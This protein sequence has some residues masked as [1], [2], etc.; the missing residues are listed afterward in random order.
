MAGN[1]VN[2]SGGG[3][4]AP[5]TWWGLGAIA[6]V[7][8][9]CGPFGLEAT[10]FYGGATWTL[11]AV[12]AVPLLYV[13]PQVLMVSEL[14][15]MMPSNHGYILWV[16]RG[17]GP[18]AG[19]FNG[20]NAVIVNTVDLALYP[21]LASD[22]V[23]RLF[24]RIGWVAEGETVG[25][26]DFSSRTYLVAIATRLTLIAV[27][28]FVGCLSTANVSS[29]SVIVCVFVT[30]V[31]VGLFCATLPEM[32]PKSQITHDAGM[33]P[34]FDGA[35]QWGPFTAAALWL[36]TGWN[37][38][39]SLAGDVD[40][41]DDDAEDGA[42]NTST[43]DKNN[44]GAMAHADGAGE[45]V[46]LVDQQPLAPMTALSEAQQRQMEATEAHHAARGLDDFYSA[47]NVRLERVPPPEILTEGD[48]TLDRSPR[49]SPR[50][51]GLAESPPQLVMPRVVIASS[52][53]PSVPFSSSSNDPL[54]ARMRGSE[55][56]TPSDPPT[57]PTSAGPISGS[58][59]SA[60]KGLNNVFVRGL[61][62]ALILGVILYLLPLLTAL[63]S[64]EAR[65][66][67]WGDGFLVAAMDMAVPG[68][69][70]MLIFIGIV[71]QFGL[72]YSSL[73]C[74]SRIVWG[75][76]ELGWLPAFFAKLG[77]RNGTP[78]NATLAQS[79]ALVPLMFF[80]F[81]YLQRLEFT[82][83]C[84]AYCLTFTAFL[85]LRYN[86]PN[87][88]RPYTVPGGL[89]IAWLITATK[90]VV[91]VTVA[92][93]NAA[94]PILLGVAVGI[95][96]LIGVAYYFSDGRKRAAELEAKEAEAEGSQSNGSA[97]AA[98]GEQV[99]TY[100]PVEMLTTTDTTVAVNSVARPF[101]G[102]YAAE[103]PRT[104]AATD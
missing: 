90:V 56:T 52:S 22:Y 15:L 78:I 9:S 76:A 43:A 92:A 60:N 14:A 40:N 34:S 50:G 80:D 65:D 88:R 25:N 53:S 7:M 74:Y 48:L 59:S 31:F 51:R 27:G 55:Q 20:Y 28:T 86:E 57:S 67:A 70:W 23:L 103:S 97:A 24:G 35:V 68:A 91:M 39:G 75:L 17:W 30:A 81:S 41:G 11:I 82:L 10:M 89:P 32:D 104:C 102:G 29:I 1:K 37:S 19:F 72:Y 12:L 2:V 36:Y 85:R 77:A 71:S 84:I 49:P 6:F 64:A 33:E 58:S 100:T 21:V 73:V 42:E 93:T 54:T 13:I 66:S 87:A 63:T 61:Q 94:D 95:N 38:L 44:N 4:K 98:A 62:F 96:G 26:F 5:L 47:V 83:A 99:S 16:Q 3:K 8:T 18:F 46:V 69:F 101:V 79:A 45:A